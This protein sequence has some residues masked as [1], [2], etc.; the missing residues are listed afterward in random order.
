MDMVG[1]ERPAGA[2]S[3]RLLEDPA[4]PVQERVPV[5]IIPKDLPTFDP[6][7]QDV[8]EGARGT[9]RTQCGRASLRA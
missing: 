6:P 4:E 2:G 9:F 8:L 1:H 5:T 3:R 7:D